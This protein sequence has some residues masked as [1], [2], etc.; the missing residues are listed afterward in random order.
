[1]F[2]LTGNTNTPLTAQK[3]SSIQQTVSNSKRNP[4]LLHEGKVIDIHP[5]STTV[6]IRL[7]S[8]DTLR[9]VR[10]LSGSANTVAGFRYLASIKNLTPTQTAQGLQDSPILT[11]IQDTIAVVAFLDGNWQM[12]RVIAFDFPR[13]SQM[14][15]NEAGLYTKLH[16]SGVYEII[17]KDGHH[18]T[19]YPDGSYVIYGP[20]TSPKDMNSIQGKGQAWNPLTTTTPINMTIH[21]VQGITIQASGGNL[22]INSGT[23]SVARVGDTVSV[24]VPGVGTCTG[25]I[26]TG[27]T[28]FK[29]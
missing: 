19:H 7:Y 3:Q 24:N 17:T 20:D 21:L 15:L 16:E 22:V 26:T 9:G 4:S 11:H 2:P 28:N 13:D 23:A 6:D 27:S 8:G 14:H 12:P 29:A 10:V 1:M 18:E 5:D 25:Q